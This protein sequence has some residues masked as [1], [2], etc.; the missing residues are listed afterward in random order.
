M[1]LFM[2]TFSSPT[3]GSGAGGSSNDDKIYVYDWPELVNRYANFTDRDHKSHG[4][5][6]PHWKEHFGAGRLIEGGNLEHKTSQFSLHKLFYE[7]A[8]RDPRRTLNP[9]EATT[10]F[11]PFDIG[12]HTCFLEANG[13]MRKSGC[14]LVQQVQDRLQELP[15]FRRHGGHD[16]L[17]I[18]AINYN[19]NYFMNAE[20]CRD[21]MQLC[22]NCTKLSIDEYLFT[23]KHRPFEA[24][25]RGINWHAVPFPAD[26]HHSNLGSALLV[27]SAT[28][29]NSD[30]SDSS[31]SS[32][33]G[34]VGKR[35]AGGTASGHRPSSPFAGV[36]DK[37]RHNNDN[38]NHD[39]Q[40]QQQQQQQHQ[41]QQH[42]QRRP[43]IHASAQ[44]VD[45][46][47][48]ATG[49]DGKWL[50]PWQRYY[51]DIDNRSGSASGGGGRSDS[52]AKAAASNSNGGK[53]HP[54]ERQITV[55]FTG[56]PRRFNEYSTNMREALV[57]SCK[58]IAAS[59]NNPNSCVHGTYDHNKMSNNELSRYSV[60]CLQPPG[61]MPSRKSVFDSILS[62]CIPVLFHPLTAKYLYEWHW[63]QELWEDVALSFDSSEE[64]KSLMNADSDHFIEQLIN[65]L[66]D[67]ES[68]GFVEGVGNGLGGVMLEK[69]KP[70]SADRVKHAIAGGRKE[71]HR[72]QQRIAEIAFQMQYSLVE[73]YTDPETG[74]STTEVA[75]ELDTEGQPLLDAYDTAMSRVLPIH[76]GRE[77][78]DRTS[79]YVQCEVLK[80]KQELQTADWCIPTGSLVDPYPKVS[81]Y[82][83]HLY[84]GQ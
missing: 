57:Q 72:R 31:S 17:A 2:W 39:Y 24:K 73:E 48:Q 41:R 9:E 52:G 49:V 4:V 50:S 68:K 60:F 65:M 1:S 13:R 82:S 27:R 38:N 42:Q 75:M 69:A 35:A 81:A 51:T 11:I 30:S 14:P 32:R 54:Y 71:I 37:R 34:L 62:G 18:F 40:Q 20:K 28:N 67:K 5:E 63:G 46:A 44:S 79:H 8:L 36:N 15:Y 29:S 78:H 64:N 19:M 66:A 25:Y 55:S 58:D 23:A 10:F 53:L 59:S 12:M 26:Y 61:D 21:F 6:F 80:G 74:I 70:S 33:R 16:H 76:A 84:R 83:N 77:R 22:W 45:A 7:R 3:T 43:P 47:M 56:S